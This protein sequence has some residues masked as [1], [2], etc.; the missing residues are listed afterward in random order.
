MKSL[1]VHLLSLS[2]FKM[3]LHHIHE[4]FHHLYEE[5]AGI[6]SFLFGQ[7]NKL[8]YYLPFTHLVHITLP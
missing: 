2:H 1:Q 8:F 4:T 6:N 7:Q 5:H 3:D